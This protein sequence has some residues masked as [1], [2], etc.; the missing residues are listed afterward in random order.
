ML[1]LGVTASITIIEIPIIVPGNAN[2][3][4]GLAFGCPIQEN[5]F[6]RHTTSL[7]ISGDY[8]ERDAVIT[9]KLI[10]EDGDDE[11]CIKANVI[12]QAA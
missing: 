12:I 3:C 6:Q 8:F 4:P 9:F 5:V 2:G 7:N 1:D 10:N 11:V